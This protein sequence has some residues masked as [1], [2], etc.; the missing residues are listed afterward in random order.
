MRGSSKPKRNLSIILLFVPTCLLALFLLHLACLGLHI[1]CVRPIATR[2]TA[3]RPFKT[4]PIQHHQNKRT[5]QESAPNITKQTITPSKR[6]AK[7]NHHSD[8]SA[9]AFKFFSGRNCNLKF[10]M[11]WISKSDSLGPREFISIQ[12]I[13]KF[14]PDA[15][16]LI[17]SNSLSAKILRPL[18]LR[19]YMITILSPDFNFLFKNTPAEHWFLNLPRRAMNRQNLSNLLRLALLYKYGGIYMDA[20]VIVLKSLSGFKNAIGAQAIEAGTGKWSRL[21]NAVMIFDENHPLLHKFMEEFAKNFDG[22]IWGHNGPYLVSRV[23]AR[24]V[25]YPV[26]WNR[27]RGLFERPRVGY[28][29][30]RVE[31]KYEGI[32]REGFGLHL[33]NRQS[34]RLE[35]EEGSVV[36]RIMMDCCVLCN[37]TVG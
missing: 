31:A 32:K 19:G 12:S 30:K 25:F 10:F 6:K 27:I 11:T 5:L 18:T 23:A 8:F 35:V 14:H 22:N 9:K 13:F 34:R 37:F 2:Y 17:V 16:L 7:R 4:Q 26:G 1:L 36:W 21:N 33:W 29:E 20:D 28:H 3:T 15:C 24:P